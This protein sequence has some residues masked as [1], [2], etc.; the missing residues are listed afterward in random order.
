M[1]DYEEFKQAFTAGLREK[2]V[3][4]NVLLYHMPVKKINSVQ[5]A[6]AVKFPDA[7]ATPL[8]YLD[9]NYERYCNGESV[10]KLAEDEVERIKLGRPFAE[11]L[12]MPS[13]AQD[14]TRQSLYCVVV[15]AN[16]NKELLKEVPHEKMEDLAVIARYKMGDDYST[17]VTYGMCQQLRMTPEEVMQ[18]ARRNTEAMEYSC[19]T[20]NEVMRDMMVANGMDAKQAEALVGRDSGRFPMY[21]LTSKDYVDGAT[22]IVCKS[23]LEQAH[24][25]IGKDFYILPSSRHELILI[26]EGIG[27]NA[28]ELQTIVQQVNRETVA[29]RDVL[30]DHVYHYD[31]LTKKVSLADVRAQAET[32]ETALKL[33]HTHRRS[34]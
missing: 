21:V 5:D 24:D 28:K 29:P 13:F 26:P 3:Q 22:A 19:R 27:S 14:E 7:I 20:M 31:S 11:T 16:M 18:Q 10:A 1:M 15:N 9:D 8:I 2:L 34:H 23:A 32:K 17:A 33:S 25:T 4:E 6:V 12:P 30:S